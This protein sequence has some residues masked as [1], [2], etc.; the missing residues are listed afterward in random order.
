MICE[1]VNFLTY[2]SYHNV[3]LIVSNSDVGAMDVCKINPP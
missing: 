3:R 1:L 2:F